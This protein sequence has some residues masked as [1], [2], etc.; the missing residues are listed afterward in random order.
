M[1]AVPISDLLDPWCPGSSSAPVFG[2]PE[3]QPASAVFFGP[4]AASE[5]K[6]S[7]GG[8]AL[9]LLCV[10]GRAF[11][12]CFVAVYGVLVMALQEPRSVTVTLL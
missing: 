9:W 7:S 2:S 5:M 8:G 1:L 11:K 6:C 12:S 3:K 10:C 4:L